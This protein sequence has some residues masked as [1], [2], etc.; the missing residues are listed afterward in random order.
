MVVP[1]PLR[2]LNAGS[3]LDYRAPWC[4]AHPPHRHCP[5]S[6]PRRPR[7]RARA[8]TGPVGPVI[9]RCTGTVVIRDPATLTRLGARTI[10]CDMSPAGPVPMMSP[11][12]PEA[13]EMWVRSVR[14]GDGP[15]RDRSMV[16]SGRGAVIGAERTLSPAG[17]S[18]GS[19]QT[20]RRRGVARPRKRRCRA[21]CWD[22]DLGGATWQGVTPTVSVPGE[23][24]V[25][26]PRNPGRRRAPARGH[27]AL[28][29]D[30]RGGVGWNGG[31]TQPR[32]RVLRG[33]WPVQGRGRPV[34]A[35]N[36]VTTV[37]SAPLVAR[38][39]QRGPT[40][41]VPGVTP[42]RVRG[43][44]CSGTGVFARPV[45]LVTVPWL[46]PVT[47]A[48]FTCCAGISGRDRTAGHAR[49]DGGRGGRLR[50]AGVGGLSWLCRARPRT[51]GRSRCR[52]R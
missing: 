46:A 12:L 50:A 6:R 30:G 21:R 26:A 49:R 35:P 43:G 39:S 13:A 7:L 36:P 47:P 1:T 4:P 10:T 27:G 41:G 19:G 37:W 14:D 34:A 48:G 20:T 17:L 33:P 40:S 31:G 22:G 15:R 29:P 25:A 2:T 5:F 11:R 42:G 23:R 38:R 18:G 32:R 44:S 16:P 3:Q 9:T 45:G 28:R 52:S 8:T 24:P 51:A